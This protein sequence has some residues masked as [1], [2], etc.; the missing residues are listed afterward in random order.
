MK[1]PEVKVSNFFNFFWI[2]L[3]Q[4]CSLSW[5]LKAQ[6]HSHNEEMKKSAYIF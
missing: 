5:T 2:N 1:F 3:V 6:I 4:N